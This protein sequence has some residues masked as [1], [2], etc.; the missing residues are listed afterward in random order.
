[1]HAPLPTRPQGVR[2]AVRALTLTALALTCGC[3]QVYPFGD[4][5]I[6]EVT[7]QPSRAYLDLDKVAIIDLNG[8]LVTESQ[9]GLFSSYTTSVADLRERLARAAED[10]WVRAVVLRVDSPGGVVTAGD[11]MRQQVLAFRRE[12]GKP[13]VA[14]FLDVAASGGYYVSVASDRIVANPTSLTGSIGVI[15]QFHNVEGLFRKLGIGTEVIKSGAMKDIGSSFRPMTDK[16][17]QTLQ[18]IN[19]SFF[20]RFLAVDKEGRPKM[21]EASIKLISDGRIVDALTALKLGMVDRIGYLE[22]ALDEARRLAGIKTSRVILYRR[23]RRANR[24]IYARSATPAA[25][26][27][28]LRGLLREFAA[29]FVARSSPRFLYLWTPTP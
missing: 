5:A 20:E 24:N 13:V 16:E 21:P 14:C 1:M 3:I 27:A 2:R 10:R 12:T 6:R 29:E 25:P 7:V 4:P 8:F 17:R 18:E 23:G 22:D 15:A 28:G 26:P 9:G 19:K 11:V